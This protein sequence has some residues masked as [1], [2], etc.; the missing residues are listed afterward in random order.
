MASIVQ[1][2]NSYAVV[3]GYTAE[4]GT[5]KQKWE[6]YHSEKEAIDRKMDLENPNVFVGTNPKIR[7]LN[8]LLDYYTD[9]HG[10]M[11]WTMSTYSENISLMKN[12][13]RPFIG[14]SN[15]MRFSKRFMSG[16]FQKLHTTPRV[17][18]K[19]KPM[20]TGPIGRTTLEEIY[21]LLRNIFQEAIHWGI[22]NDNPILHIAL[23]KP[24]RTPKLMLAP[25]QILALIN[26]SIKREDFVLALLVQFAF[27]CSM[28]K[29]EILG[30]HWSEVNLEEGCLQVTQELSRETVDSLEMLN[31]KGVYHVFQPYMDGSK[32]RLVLK[33]PKTY[34]SRRT[35]YLPQTF[36]LFLRRWKEQQQKQKDLM[37]ADYEDFDLVIAKENG[38]PLCPRRATN[39]FVNMAVAL[40]LPKVH[41]H[42]LRYSST[43]YKLILSHGNVKAVQGDTG[44]AQPNMVL[45]IYAQIQDRQRM[46]LAR[47]VDDGF[48]LNIQPMP[49]QSPNDIS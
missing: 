47:E 1:R 28:R 30:L 37:G 16:Y 23:S 25:E 6:T 26:E 46:I 33:E 5:R 18:H 35:I 8:D 14:D 44:H 31:Y 34:S 12:Y 20:D 21:K 39:L 32:S 19:Y 49:V 48:C 22:I 38:R 43:S 2:H 40:G 4:D 10:R 36:I 27:L 11:H 13:I 45:S 17:V 15:L 9:V 42:S 3:Y 24:Y 29:G 41:F 7:T